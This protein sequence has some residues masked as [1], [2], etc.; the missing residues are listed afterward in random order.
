[1]VVEEVDDWTG[2]SSSMIQGQLFCLSVPAHENITTTD[3][4]EALLLG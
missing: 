2:S 1:M 3:N 4:S